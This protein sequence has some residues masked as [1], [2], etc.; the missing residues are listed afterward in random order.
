MLSSREL[1]SC[2][3]KIVN[4]Y[5]LNDKRNITPH[6]LWECL[7]YIRDLE[8]IPD[9]SDKQEV[10][11]GVVK[12]FRRIVAS[13]K[14]KIAE[15]DSSTIMC[16][17]LLDGQTLYKLSVQ[18]YL[19]FP[20]VP[21]VDVAD[22]QKI[23]WMTEG[24]DEHGR[25]Y[26]HYDS[27][28]VD[29][30]VVHNPFIRAELIRYTVAEASVCYAKE[31]G[32]VARAIGK[33]YD[34]KI[35]K[36][37]PLDRITSSDIS[38]LKTLCVD[39]NGGYSNHLQP[40]LIKFLQYLNFKH[41]NF[42]DESGFRLLAMHSTV[43]NRVKAIPDGDFKILEDALRIR[44]DI[45]G[46]R[47]AIA[48]NRYIGEVRGFQFYMAFLLLSRTK[49]RPD[50]LFNLDKDDIFPGQKEGVYIIQAKTKKSGGKLEQ[51]VLSDMT[52]SILQDC[53]S[54]ANM[55]I[56]KY[57][58]K[59]PKFL[60][61]IFLIVRPDGVPSTITTSFF[62]Q[63]MA[64][65]CKEIGIPEYGADS[66]RKRYMTKAEDLANE[67]CLS[68]LDRAQLTGHASEDVT[69]DSYFTFETSKLVEGLY[70]VTIGD[71]RLLNIID[72]KN[73]IVDI[74]LDDGRLV[75]GEVDKELGYCT[76]ECQGNSVIACYCC[77][78]FKTTVAHLPNFK[79]EFKRL[80]FMKTHTSN[81]HDVETIELKQNVVAMY[82]AAIYEKMEEKH[83]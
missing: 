16:K 43:R 8:E 72:A 38:Y 58:I 3:M 36:K 13:D 74:E 29:Y 51:I 55:K 61:K 46:I 73:K 37:I 66:L 54:I 32:S 47:K 7:I 39:E 60:N 65:V 52:Y 48:E 42:V 83:D 18:G 15:F 28:S 14:R 56:G 27:F 77:Q 79:N 53:I 82:I 50:T 69:I 64:N 21:D 30:S 25:R 80:Q 62:G 81:E 2:L 11:L 31:I 19:P 41:P 40:Y 59:E 70:H 34:F 76:S 1:T 22:A 45:P 5:H 9:D 4:L 63:Y 26:S 20:F 75:G 24:W 67:E 12:H 71:Q 78:H 23:I 17:K 35:E 49:M 44:A 33:L 10:S 6:K 57:K 68:V